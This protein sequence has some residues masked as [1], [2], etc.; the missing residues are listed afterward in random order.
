MP[1]E[2]YNS[3]S[4]KK[5]FCP[6]GDLFHWLFAIDILER[7]YNHENIPSVRRASSKAIESGLISFDVIWKTSKFNNPTGL[8]LNGPIAG[9]YVSKWHERKEV[10]FVVKRR[11][12]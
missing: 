10:V 1:I 7:K 12:A 2:R 6:D 3:E 8:C 11:G 4:F 5:P 9:Y